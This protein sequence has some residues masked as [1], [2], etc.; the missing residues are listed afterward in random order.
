[1]EDGREGLVA[2]SLVH[3]VPA[4]FDVAPAGFCW[5]VP[6]LGHQRLAH[7]RKLVTVGARSIFNLE[8]HLLVAGLFFDWDGIDVV[9]VTE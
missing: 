1:M 4:P 3:V 2:E 9:A 5:S 6:P 8:D 7:E